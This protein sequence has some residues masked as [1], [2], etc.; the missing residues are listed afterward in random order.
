ML[1]RLAEL[2]ALPESQVLAIESDLRAQWGGERAYIARLGECGARMQAVRD[3][4]IREQYRQG[5]SVKLLAR[6]WVLS[7]RHIRRIV[8]A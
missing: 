7:D 5:E 4:R 8:C 3:I 2:V 1:Q 6:R